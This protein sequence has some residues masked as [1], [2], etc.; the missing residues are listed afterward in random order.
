MGMASRTRIAGAAGRRV[1]W[2]GGAFAL[3]RHNGLDGVFPGYN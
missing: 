1:F 3:A 2:Q